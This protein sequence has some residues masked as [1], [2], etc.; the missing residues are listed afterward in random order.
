MTKD[1]KELLESF[2]EE[3]ELADAHPLLGNRKLSTLVHVWS[4]ARVEWI[5]PEELEDVPKLLADQW[6]L[7]WSY[8]HWSMEEISV[9]SNLTLTET[10]ELLLRARTLRLIYPDGSVSPHARDILGLKVSQEMKRL[11]SKRGRPPKVDSKASKEGI[12]A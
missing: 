8:S 5:P 7:L 4:K 1:P 9:V 12:Q 11:Y 3:D 2:R 10:G 6:D